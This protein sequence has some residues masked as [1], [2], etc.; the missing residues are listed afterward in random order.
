MNKYCVNTTSDNKSRLSQYHDLSASLSKLTDQQLLQFLKKENFFKQGIGGKCG[1]IKNSGVSLFVKRIPL[2]AIEHGARNT[3]STEN[4]FNLPNY[5]QYGIGSPGFGAWR[6][7]TAIEMSNSWVFK[8]KSNNFPIMYHWRVLPKENFVPTQEDL[9]QMER[10]IQVWDDLPEIRT[11]FE[12]RLH[13]AF[14]LIVFLEYFPSNLDTWLS[15][16]FDMSDNTAESACLMV[17]KEL[18]STT[19]FMNSHQLLHFDA[20][21]HNILTDGN[22]LYFSDFVLAISPLF[23]LSKS[24]INFYHQHHNYDRCFVMAYFVEWI[25]TKYFGADNWF[26]GKYNNILQEYVD[27]SGKPLPSKIKTIVNRYAP[28]A[29]RM[30]NFFVELKQSK[31]TPY[32]TAELE[33]AFNTKLI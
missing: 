13:A 18:L 6:E 10:D 29:L 24:E 21:F 20:H 9:N 3:L 19:N 17:E 31:L 7:L 14:E 32:P 16:Q 25:L 15:Q 22:R 5:C 33:N 12:E 8:G 30:H 27:G 1:I 26:S 2:S 4:I 28:L 11:C 23:D